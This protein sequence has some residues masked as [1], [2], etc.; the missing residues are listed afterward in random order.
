MAWLFIVA[1]GIFETGFAV[2]LKM[3]HGMTRLGS[4]VGFA[5]CALA[6]LGAAGPNGTGRE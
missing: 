3:S 1:A 6:S 5:L 2:A 4:T